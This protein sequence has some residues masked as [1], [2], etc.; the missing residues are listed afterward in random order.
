MFQTFQRAVLALTPALAVGLCMASPSRVPAA[1]AVG[2]RD[3]FVVYQRDQSSQEGTRWFQKEIGVVGS[4]LAPPRADAAPAFLLAGNNSNCQPAPPQCHPSP[5]PPPPTPTPVCCN[6]GCVSKGQCPPTPPPCPTPVPRPTPTP[7][8][9][10]T[11]TPTPKPTPPP[12][13]H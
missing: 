10:A 5:P 8:P 3:A 7:C 11:P 1:S 6:C 13:G 9:K 2:S 4:R 12:C